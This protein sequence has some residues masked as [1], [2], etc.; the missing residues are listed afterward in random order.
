[1]VF[2]LFTRCAIILIKD[3]LSLPKKRILK[4]FGNVERP[5]FERIRAGLRPVRGLVYIYLTRTLIASAP[6][7]FPNFKIFPTDKIYIDVKGPFSLQ[8]PM[9]MDPVPS[10]IQHWREC[11]PPSST[12]VFLETT[13]LASCG[14]FY[15]TTFCKYRLNF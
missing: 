4:H 15:L 1:M 7:F 2:K 12:C 14:I 3:V 9:H 5:F 13:F 10:S 11:P 8:A 6:L